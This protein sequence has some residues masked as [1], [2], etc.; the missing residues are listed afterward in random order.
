MVATRNRG[1][2]EGADV[3]ALHTAVVYSIR[4]E[5][6]DM[7]EATKEHWLDRKSVV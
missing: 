5:K 2:G 3:L 6:G 1:I 7:N 4:T